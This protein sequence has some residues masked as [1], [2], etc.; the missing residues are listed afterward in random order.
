[1]KKLFS[2]LLLIVV[3]SALGIFYLPKYLSVASIDVPTEI[4]VPKGASL[5]YV[6]DLLYNN[7]I[8]RSRLWFKHQAKAKNIDR[9]IKPGTYV[10]APSMSL[11]EIFQLLQKGEQIRQVVLTIPEGFTIYQIAQRVEALGFGS[12]NEFIAVTK[13]YFKEEKLAFDTRKLFFE[14][15]GYLYPDTYYFNETQTHKDI[16]ARMA[17]QMKDVFTDEY[18][19][20]A[21]DL[22]LTIHEVL[23]IASLIEREAYHDNEKAAISGVIYNR[24]KEKMP[25][26]IDATVI[27]AIGGGKEHISRVLYTHLE[28]ANP[29]NTYKHNGLPPGPIAAP[30]KKSIEATL[31]PEKHDYMYYVLGDN[32]HVFSETY[33][34]HLV[35]VEKYRKKVKN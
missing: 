26:Q 2:L 1:M 21:E 34:Q 24:I 6:S 32:G 30:G 35:H 4:I 16:V 14:L 33:S 20:R 18:K 29:F 12:A 9:N 31:Y 13:E 27:Y 7:K 17:K 10:I 15:E 25:L 3:I 8:I 11:G 19:D 23:T 22:G 28:S 5:T